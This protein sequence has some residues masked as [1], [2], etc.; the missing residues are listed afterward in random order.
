MISVMTHDDHDNGKVGVSHGA[1]EWLTIGEAARRLKVTRAAIY[2]RIERKT[3]PTKPRGNRGQLVYLPVSELL[4]GATGDHR[5]DVAHDDQG[6]ITPDGHG[7]AAPR[8]RD[9][10][11]LGILIELR[12]MLV[13]T[14]TERDQAR[15]EAARTRQLEDEVG[16][17]RVELAKT[18]A[19]QQ[20]IKAV[21]IADVAAARE[22]AA[23]ELAAQGRLLER[24]QRRVDEL[25]AELRDLTRELEW[26]RRSWWRRLFS[27]RSRLHRRSPEV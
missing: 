2:G 20:A 11:L 6:S 19:E 5:P 15:A 10:R 4:S 21:A 7:D 12:D 17:L 18:Q 22:V 1:G 8:S 13:R 9:D 3:L 24:E 27:R 14:R 26:Y 23:A 16:R 25:T